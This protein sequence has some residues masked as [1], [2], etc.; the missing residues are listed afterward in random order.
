MEFILVGA[1]LTLLTVAV[2]QLGF[3]VYT[4]NVVQDAAVDAAYRAA[5]ADAR[6]GEAATRADELIARAVGDGYAREVSVTSGAVAGVDSVVVTISAAL[7]LAGP[8]GLSGALEVTAHAPRES[9]G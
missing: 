9:L 6:P 4:R 1:L 2:L 5:L 7:P 8:F 3:A